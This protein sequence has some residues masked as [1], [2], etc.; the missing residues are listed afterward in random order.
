MVYRVISL[1]RANRQ[2]F[3]RFTKGVIKKIKKSKVITYEGHNRATRELYLSFPNNEIADK[4]MN[5][6]GKIIKNY[7]YEAEYKRKA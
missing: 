3:Q 5:D 1:P 4:V 2:Q 7:G 6:V